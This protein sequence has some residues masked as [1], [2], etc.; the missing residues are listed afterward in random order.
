M[1]KQWRT[2]GEG[3]LLWQLPH[4]S[5]ILSALFCNGIR[6]RDA[7]A[8]KGGSIIGQQEIISM[9]QVKDMAH[10]RP[11][12]S[13]KQVGQQQQQQLREE[14]SGRQAGSWQLGQQEWSGRQLGQAPEE[15]AKLQL[16]QIFVY[17]LTRNIFTVHKQPQQDAAQ[18]PHTFPPN[19]TNPSNNKQAEITSKT[20]G[21]RKL[22]NI[23]KN[24]VKREWERGESGESKE[25][26][27]SIII[28]WN[29]YAT[30]FGIFSLGIEINVIRIAG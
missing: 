17:E 24:I 27:I 18:S 19:T 12:Q 10:R 3:E 8:A 15:E 30:H 21:K 25:Q 20:L 29:L 11:Q 6:R 16:Q 26:D 28:F 14:W 2:E 5:H 9:Q 4:G 1:N 13:L 23:M 7:A 22:A